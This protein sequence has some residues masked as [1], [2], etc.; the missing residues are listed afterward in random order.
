MDI[1][2]DDMSLDDLKQL[3]KDVEKAIHTYEQ[4]QKADA[5][6]ELEEHAK[7]L[8]F[9]LEELVSDKSI[10]KTKQPVQPKYQH[11]ENPSLTWSGRGRKPKFVLEHL[12][13]GGNID[14]LLIK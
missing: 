2:L 14:D 3:R 11:P 1:D 9:K 12:D 6:L 13:N 5:K 7:Q 4:R 8:G 10:K